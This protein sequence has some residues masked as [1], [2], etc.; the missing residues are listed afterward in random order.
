[1]HFVARRFRDRRVVLGG[2][3]IG[4]LCSV[5]ATGGCS[6]TPTVRLQPTPQPHPTAMSLLADVARSGVSCQQRVEEP[7]PKSVKALV[8]CDP[9]SL[10][11][12]GHVA[13]LVVA[14]PLLQ[15]QWLSL[16]GR[17]VQGGGNAAVIAGRTWAIVLPG[18]HST[19]SSQAALAARIAG[20]TG[21]QVLRG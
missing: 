19:R 14:A 7:A 8:V 11:I 1:M 3:I 9:A 13:A 18:P 2:P 10:G 20:A 21:G 5:V 6:A 4:I 17:D 12:M 15:T 16:V